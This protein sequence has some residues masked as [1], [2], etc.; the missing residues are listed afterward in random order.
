MDPNVTIS[1]RPPSFLRM[2]D[3]ALQIG[4]VASTDLCL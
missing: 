2:L 1:E 3:A 4:L